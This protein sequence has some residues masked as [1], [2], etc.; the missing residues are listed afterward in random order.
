M[1]WGLALLAAPPAAAV[2]AVCCLA[3]SCKATSSSREVQQQQLSCS[4]ASCEEVL[5]LAAAVKVTHHMRQVEAVCWVLCARWVK[6]G[7]TLTGT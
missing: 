7:A 6:R 1:S 5:Q 4:R 3:V 2:Q